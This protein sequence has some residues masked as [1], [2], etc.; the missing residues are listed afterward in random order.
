MQRKYICFSCPAALGLGETAASHPTRWSD[1]LFCSSW[2][3]DLIERRRRKGV[4]SA[5]GRLGG[6]MEEGACPA[7]KDLAKCSH[8][9]SCGPSV[10]RGRVCAG[11]M[12]LLWPPTP[13]SP[14]LSFCSSYLTI[15]TPFSSAQ[16]SPLSVHSAQPGSEP[17]WVS[18]QA[19]CSLTPPQHTPALV[20]PTVFPKG[21][22]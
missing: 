21:G 14:A 19:P 7:N 18:R 22:E 8:C 2:T 3:G 10:G 15:S 9:L 20:P 4:K 12:L 5:H 13:S 16:S 11:A 6:D 17:E 1:V